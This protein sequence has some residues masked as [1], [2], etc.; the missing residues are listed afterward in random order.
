[1]RTTKRYLNGNLVELNFY[2]TFQEI[3]QELNRLYN[4]K[5]LSEPIDIDE[6]TT[7]LTLYVEREKWIKGKIFSRLLA[8][9]EN[10]SRQFK[11]K[12]GGAYSVIY[13]EVMVEVEAIPRELNPV[14]REGLAICSAPQFGLDKDEMVSY[15]MA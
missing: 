5:T 2:G 14:S 1:M 11:G 9:S 10:R 12:K 8:M 3:S 15:A 7:F 4:S 13:E 6:G